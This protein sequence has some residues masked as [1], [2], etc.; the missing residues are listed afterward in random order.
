ME[1]NNNNSQQ[2]QYK[3]SYAREQ[4]DKLV[5][6]FVEQL[7]KGDIGSWK[8]SNSKKIVFCYYKL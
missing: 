7:E 4:Y 2:T 6:N 8:K 3:K 5:N 1:E